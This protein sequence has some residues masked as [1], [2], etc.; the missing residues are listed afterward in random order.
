VA[1]TRAAEPDR[2][3]IA[4]IERE[5][6]A[7]LVRYRRTRNAREL[8]ATMARLDTEAALAELVDDVA[9]IPADEAVAYLRDLPGLWAD[10]PGS[11][12]AI[13]EALFESIEVLGLRTMRLHPT[14][15]AIDRGLGDAFAAR[16]HGYGRG[17][18]I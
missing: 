2:V 15:A 18:R 7:A 17:E 10:A 6:D 8:E 16:T 1:D 9:P 12:R 14:R 5:R 4:R 11:R 3:T 13:A